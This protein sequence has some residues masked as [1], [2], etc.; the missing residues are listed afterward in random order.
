[1]LVA[2]EVLGYIVDIVSAARA[3]FPV[4]P[5]RRLTA[6]RH[7]TA[8]HRT[9]VGLAFR[10]ELC[11]PRRCQGHGAVD[12]AP[13]H[14]T[15]AEAELEGANPT[16]CST[17]PAS[18][19]VPPLW[20]SPTYWPGRADRGHPDRVLTAGGQRFSLPR[21]RLYWFWSSST[22]PSRPTSSP[23]TSAGAATHPLDWDNPSTPSRS[24]QRTSPLP[25]MV[26]DGWPLSARA[27]PR[28]HIVS[29][30]ARPVHHEHHPS[31]AATPRRS[32]IR[33]CD[34]TLHRSAR[35]RGQAGP[36]A[37]PGRSAFCRRSWHANTCRLVLARLREIDGML[38][39]LIRGRNRIRFTSRICRG[40]RR[41][42]HRLEGNRAPRR[43]RRPNVAP[44]A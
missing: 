41:A 15:A 33:H 43:R 12:V 1:M 10:T 40:R 31:V 42:L 18:V 20:S 16:E 21:W 36:N 7:R 24:P 19:P 14:R 27:E 6:R 2:D 37:R 32:A 23:F 44:R 13:P 35:T 39:V 28:V 38:P 34:D 9:F 4:T 8:R 5:A 17:D 11:D 30:G 3:V 29:I 22:S 25:G 26:R